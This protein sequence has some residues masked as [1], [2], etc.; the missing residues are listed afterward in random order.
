M[1][2]PWPCVQSRLIGTGMPITTDRY[3]RSYR[4]VYARWTLCLPEMR[5]R[6]RLEPELVVCRPRISG[7]IDRHLEPRKHGD[8]S[9]TPSPPTPLDTSPFLVGS[10]SLGRPV[11][12]WD[13]HM[14]TNPGPAG[15][16]S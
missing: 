16:W 1:Y 8:V 15:G 5:G 3:F 9:P 12:L 11:W 10:V 4:T 2:S 14:R 6:Y 7:G 13:E